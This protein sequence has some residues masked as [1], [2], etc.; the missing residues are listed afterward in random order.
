MMQYSVGKNSVAARTLALIVLVL[1]IF[2]VAPLSQGAE[3]TYL[4]DGEVLSKFGN[5]MATVAERVKPSIV[6][7]STTRIVKTPRNPLFDDPFFRRF[8]GD[9]FQT[10]QKRK[11]TSLGS[12]VI[13]T[14]DGFILTNNHVIDGAEDIL[15]KLTDNREFK[16]KVIGTDARTDIAI[17][18]IEQNN[19][20]TIPWG[21][22]DKLRVGEIVLAIGNP[23]GLSQTITMGIISALG[24]SGIGI[25]DFEDFIQTDAAIN[26]GNSGGALVNIRGE[27]IGINTAIFSTSGGYQGIGFAIPSGMVHGIMESITTQG[28][29]VRGWLGVQI[30][31]LTPELAKQFNLKDEQGVLLVD[32]VDEGPA[33]KGG[34]RRGDVIV[35]YEGKKVESPFGLRNMVAATK[36]G[37]A[38]EVTVLRDG[39]AE[40][41][42]VTIG[43]LPA[44]AQASAPATTQTENNLKGVTV[45]DLTDEMLQKM[46]ITRKIQGV[47][48][49][50]VDE[51]SPAA[52]RIAKGDVIIEINRKPVKNVKD[53]EALVSAIGKNQDILLWVMRNNAF[54]AIVITSQ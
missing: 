42:R 17:I 12:G 24:R 44:E 49:S 26:P 34:L 43:E 54:L 45:Q 33:D 50:D 46:G 36:P 32:V 31:P 15:V 1:A 37:K 20:P 29:V 40:T 41:V 39:K 18:K 16:G 30:Q 14:S 8:F 52:N 7:I 38:V 53:Y 51:G 28:K 2:T 23:Y 21:D 13:A 22:S 27:L 25:T 35:Q 47:V 6:N 4:D 11:V 10:P 9:G 3:K 5:A 19:L 48:V